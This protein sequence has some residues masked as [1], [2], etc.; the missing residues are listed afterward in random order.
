[1][2]NKKRGDRPNLLDPSQVPQKPEGET[3]EMIGNSL[4]G[5][6]EGLADLF[7]PKKVPAKRERPVIP[8][9]Y[10]EKGT[11]GMPWTRKDPVPER[12]TIEDAPN[13]LPDTG[14]PLPPKP[15]YV[16]ER[17]HVTG[18][19]T[20]RKGL[21]RPPGYEKP[22]SPEKRPEPK[23]KWAWG[24]MISKG[25]LAHFNDGHTGQVPPR[26]R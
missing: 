21:K 15:E 11:E 19:K 6:G 24:G 17:E 10:V 26:S 7:A 3:A 12:G 14:I 5:W 16:D 20:G 13:P 4:E 18:Q 2:A 1:M 9:K 25:A 8:M 23:K 22:P